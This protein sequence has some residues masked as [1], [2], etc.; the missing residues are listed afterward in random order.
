MQPNVTA[1]EAPCGKAAHAGDANNV[2]IIGAGIIGACVASYL[3]RDGR[4]VT[5][6][7]QA[8]SPAP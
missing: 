3:Q 6:I 5:L 1:L 2:V 8:T 4:Q 7:D